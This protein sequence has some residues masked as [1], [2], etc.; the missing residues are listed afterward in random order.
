MEVILIGS[1]GCMRELAWQMIEQNQKEKTDWVISGF[2]DKES[3]K[4][5]VYASEQEIPYL[6]NDDYLLA[7]DKPV[8]VVMTVGSSK[9]RKII[10]E[11]IGRNQNIKFPNIIL[12]NVS[13]CKDLKIGKGCVISKNTCI[14]TNVT[15]G[16]FVFINMENLICHDC[17]IDDY[18]TLSPS[19]KL[20]GTVKIG[21][22]T[23]VGIGS[24][25]IQ[26]INIGSNVML[27]AGS[28]AVSDIES[29]VVA[30]GI[31]AKKIKEN[32]Q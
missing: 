32:K 29:N 8:N 4:S 30:V 16:D 21:K 18:A 2:V 6:G 9:L 31:P 20:A 17:V 25:I 22:E 11:K 19:V 13:L 3:P 7:L 1:G 10:A 27:G 24:Q 14:S 5:K 23:S 26:G 15:I 28:V 12:G